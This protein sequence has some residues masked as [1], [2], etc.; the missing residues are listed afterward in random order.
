[1]GV[2]HNHYNQYGM[3]ANEAWGRPRD[4]KIYPGKEGFS[5]YSQSLYHRYLNLGK[6]YPVTAGSASGVLQAPPGY[7]RV[8]VYAPE[9]LTVENFYTALK[10]RTEFCNQWADPHLYRRWEGSG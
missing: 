2:V 4:Q 9:G 10:G 8:Y 6:R 5:N 1:M 3:M 7:N